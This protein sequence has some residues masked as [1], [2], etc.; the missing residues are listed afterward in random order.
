[1]NY[2]EIIEQLTEEQ[3]EASEEPQLVRVEVQ[4]KNA[5][6]TLYPGYEE[7]FTGVSYIVQY[8]EHSHSA[9]GE[10]TPCKITIIK[11]VS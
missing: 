1:M 3:I 8:H 5:A 2:L 11:E 6:E 4:N 10:N 7:D 9:M